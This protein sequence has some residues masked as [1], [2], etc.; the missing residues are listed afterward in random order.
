MSRNSHASK[1]ESTGFSSSNEASTPLVAEREAT[2][3]QLRFI[4][5]TCGFSPASLAVAIGVSS[6][7]LLAALALAMT[8]GWLITR[9]WQAPP[10]LELSVAVT[11]V[12]ALGI[13]R[14]VFRYAD[15]LYAHRL[16]LRTTTRLRSAIFNEL[17][18]SQVDLGPRGRAHV[19]L[20]DDADKITDLIVRTLVPCG[21]AAVL[22]VVSLICAFLMSVPAAL[23]MAGAFALTGIA[24]PALVAQAS[25]KS[26]ATSTRNAF[27]ENLDNTLH[28]RVEFAAAGRG[29]LLRNLAARASRRETSA[30]VAADRPLAV[31]DALSSGAIGCAAVGVLI[32]A[33]AFYTGNPMWMGTLVLLALSS[34]EAHAA[35]PQAAQSWQEASGSIHS[36]SA[37]LK[38]PPRPQP[39]FTDTRFVRARNLRTEFGDT[40]WNF[41]ALPGQRV[42][43]RGKSGS[44]QT[45]LLET[46]AGVRE[47]I[48]GEVTRPASCI[49]SAEDAWIFATSV[50]ENIRVAAPEASET[51]MS[52]TLAAVGFELDLDTQLS[53]GADSLSSGQRRRLLLARALCT[54]AEVLLLDEP[55]EHIAASDSARLLN[56]LCTQPLPG[57][58]PERTVIIVTHAPGPVGIEVLSPA[59]LA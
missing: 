14:A 4:F 11:S 37:V 36:L 18:D 20:V 9:A 59:H 56:V 5:S 6:L 16:A 8:S 34:F 27:T 38:A 23:V 43:V 13:S 26:Q 28:N 31:A 47:A 52:T 58:L 46:I 7:A 53:D 12:R 24:V 33:L 3:T 42:V 41:E 49:L 15:R 50:R 29:E 55:T 39:R 21:V 30:R 45:M 44:G 51:L 25:R 22:S 57:A 19:R 10:V 54:K 48:S 17:I 2:L 40:V 32:C 1:A 35:L